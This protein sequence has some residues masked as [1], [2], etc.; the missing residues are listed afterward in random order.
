MSKLHVQTLNSTYVVDEDAGTVTRYTPF[1]SENSLTADGEPLR[2]L[3][4]VIA[5]GTSAFFWVEYPDGTLHSRTTSI[6]V[7]IKEMDE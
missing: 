5:E 7:S 2:Y 6:V 1:E 4:S 3:A